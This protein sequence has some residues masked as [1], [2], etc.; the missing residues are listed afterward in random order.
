[1]KQDQT[2]LQAIAAAIEEMGRAIDRLGVRLSAVAATDPR[3]LLH[4]IA[5]ELH[6]GFDL[7]TAALERMNEL[8][9]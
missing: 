5:T 9:P 3:D 1:M 2:E 6:E 7:V 8:K 4:T